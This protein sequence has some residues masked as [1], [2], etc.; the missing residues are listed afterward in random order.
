MSA[1]EHTGFKDL[2]QNTGFVTWIDYVASNDGELLKISEGRCFS[3]SRRTNPQTLM[4]A[5]TSSQIYIV[6]A[7]PY[8][9]NLTC[10]GSSGGEAVLFGSKGEELHSI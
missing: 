1:K 4:H 9:P 7:N 10:E 6:T 3:T 2:V 5:A 8:N